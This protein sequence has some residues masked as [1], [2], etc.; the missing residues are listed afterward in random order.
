[1]QCA[2]RAMPLASGPRCESAPIM[3]GIPCC[4]A[5]PSL[6]PTIPA[7]P[8]IS[9]A[10]GSLLNRLSKLEPRAPGLHDLSANE[11]QPP[12][13]IEVRPRTGA[14][15]AHRRRCIRL[16]QLTNQ[17]ARH[18]EQSCELLNSAVALCE[19][20]LPAAESHRSIENPAAFQLFRADEV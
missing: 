18:T 5:L 20:V 13:V 15:R 8:H 17:V 2:N 6:G 12:L 9:T 1:M 3:A 14:Q 16:E 11:S 7:I 19:T 4:S 10:F